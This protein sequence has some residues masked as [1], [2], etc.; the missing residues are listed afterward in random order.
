MGGALHVSFWRDPCSRRRSAR[1]N[2]WPPFNAA[3]EHF[4][5]DALQQRRQR[6]SARKSGGCSLAQPEREEAGNEMN[7]PRGQQFDMGDSCLSGGR[8]WRW[9]LRGAPRF[10]DFSPVE[11]NVWP[12]LPEVFAVPELGRFSSPYSSEGRLLSLCGGSQASRPSLP[13]AVFELG[14]QRVV[15]EGGP[16][17]MLEI[18]WLGPEVGWGACALEDLELGQFVCEYAG[19]VVEDV[20]AERRCEAAGATAGRDAYLFNLTTPAQCRALGAGVRLHREVDNDPVFVVDAYSTGGVGRFLNHA[21]GPSLRA[22]VTPMFVFTAERE[23]ALI[24]AR[25]PRVAFFANRRIPRGEELCYD[26][27]MRPN[28]VDDG[29][30]G[31]R[32]LACHCGS[33]VCRGRIY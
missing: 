7:F 17:V 1:E 10:P 19:E 8:N 30:G 18:S 13:P 24:D 4:S 20:E 25:L 32:S 9:Q 12:Q 31:V 28:D 33:E 2:A 6:C 26:Y 22:N 29:V 15:R 23:S 16:R 14:S 21:C 11:D 5:E 27:D 3:E